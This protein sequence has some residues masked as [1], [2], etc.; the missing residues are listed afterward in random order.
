MIYKIPLNEY[1][2]GIDYRSLSTHPLLKGFEIIQT[3]EPIKGLVECAK[4]SIEVTHL[5]DY[6]KCELEYTQAKPKEE[7]EYDRGAR[8]MAEAL[9]LVAAIAPIDTKRMEL[10][11]VDSARV[12]EAIKADPVKWDAAAAVAAVEAEPLE[13]EVKR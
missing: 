9:T 6:E 12:I 7:T 13:G 5:G 11:K 2:I 4:D 10:A 1:P 3:K 8:E